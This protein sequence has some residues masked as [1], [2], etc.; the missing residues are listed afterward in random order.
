[1]PAQTHR[2]TL[3]LFGMLIGLWAIVPP[4]VALFGKVEVRD[5]AVE[6]VDHA[7][8]GLVVIAVAVFGYLHLRDGEPSQ[9]L[10]FAAGAIITLAG[11]WM[12]STHVGLLGQTRRGMVPGGAVAWHGLPGIGVTVLGVAWSARFW[13]E[14]SAEEA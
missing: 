1:M 9:L 13:A 12:L 3:P 7:L 8:P 14:D 5:S 11:F 2:S 4:Y 10:L 6:F